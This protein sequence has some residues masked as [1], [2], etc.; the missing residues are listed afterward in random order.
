MGAVAAALAGGRFSCALAI[1]VAGLGVLLLAQGLVFSVHN[2]VVLARDD[3]RQ[4]AR[5]WMVENIPAGTKIVVEPIA[6]DQWAADVGQPLF[7]A[8]GSGNRWNKWRTS[9]SCVS[10]D[11]TLIR[12]ACPRGQARG[13][14]A[15][16]A[17]GARRRPTSA[18]GSAGSSPARTS[19]AARTP[20]RDE[21]P[22]ALRYYDEL[23]KRAARSSTASART[24]ATPSASR[25]RST[26]RSTTT[27]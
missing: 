3:T 5:D 21:V 13:L 22:D 19:S 24:G 27:R 16:D 12:G 25:S 9:R 23:R 15:H 10:N 20:T 17:P 1:P 18:A 2:D 26:T 4:L 8:T 14:R 6:P 11:G 7:S